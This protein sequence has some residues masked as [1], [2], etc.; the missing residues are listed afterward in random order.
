MKI[1][2]DV[3]SRASIDEAIRKLTAY[4]DGLEQKTEELKRRLASE[5]ILV[6]EE[7]F[8]SAIYDGTNDVHVDLVDGEDKVAIRASGDTVLFIEFGT[9]VNLPTYHPKR[10]ELQVGDV[11]TYGYGLGKLKGGWRYPESKGKGTNGEEDPDHP[12]YIHTYGNPA[13]MPMYNASK[14]IR[15]RVLEIAKEVFQGGR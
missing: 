5:G 7:Q 3:F 10:E 6:A 2:L 8:G 14:E 11:G 9:G 1:S 4:A 15:S 12:G 13:N